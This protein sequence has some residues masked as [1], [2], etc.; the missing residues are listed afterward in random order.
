MEGIATPSLPHAAMIVKVQKC[1]N[2]LKIDAINSFSGHWTVSNEMEERFS[3]LRLRSVYDNILWLQLLYNCIIF[4]LLGFLHII[5]FGTYSFPAIFKC[6]HSTIFTL[7][8]I[9]L[10]LSLVLWL[11][12]YLTCRELYC[13]KLS[14][15]Y[16]IV[17]CTLW[18][19]C[20]EF[21]NRLTRKVPHVSGSV[22]S[23]RS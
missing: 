5:S 3:W 7:N 12:L 2:A 20:V 21:R 15:I 18:S 17:L 4:T 1:Q 6:Y 22:F 14:R 13:C 19:T 16:L 23:N 9:I 8:V 10:R 11:F